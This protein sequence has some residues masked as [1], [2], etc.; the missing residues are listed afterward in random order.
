[1]DWSLQPV[2]YGGQ[3]LD[4]KFNVALNE[5]LGHIRCGA[6]PMSIAVQVCPI[7]NLAFLARKGCV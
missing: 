4:L 7:D 5:T 6:I 3:G 1:L 2:E